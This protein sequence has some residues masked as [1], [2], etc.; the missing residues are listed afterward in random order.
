MCPVTFVT[1]CMYAWWH[2]LLTEMCSI[3]DGRFIFGWLAHIVSV[4]THSRRQQCVC[5]NVFNF[6]AKRKAGITGFAW[7]LNCNPNL[8]RP[9]WGVVLFL[10]IL[11]HNWTRHAITTN[12][13]LNDR[14]NHR[15]RRRVIIARHYGVNFLDTFLINCVAREIRR[16]VVGAIRVALM[17]IYSQ[18]M[19][20]IL[21]FRAVLFIL[22]ANDRGVWWLIAIGL[23]AYYYLF[24]EYSNTHPN[25]NLC[26]FLYKY[27]GFRWSCT[28]NNMSKHRLNYV[29]P[30]YTLR[31]NMLN[32]CRNSSKV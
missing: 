12:N 18:S 4:S 19:D 13:T 20:E 17:Q 1:Y 26:I 28:S 14:V 30:R 29:I 25:Q 27:V 2:V 3:A 8:L 21:W 32:R 15:A 10:N 5:V 22:I 31:C 9:I 23:A 24:K 6:P 11:Q 16:G 7:V